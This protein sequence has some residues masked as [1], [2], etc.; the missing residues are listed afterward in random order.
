MTHL[1]VLMCLAIV[2]SSMTIR[3][4]TLAATEPLYKQIDALVT[5]HTGFRDRAA[6][7][8]NDASFLRRIHLDL[9]G[10]IPTAQQ[11]RDF[12]ADSAADK[13]VELIDKL[14]DS[15]QYARRMQVVFDVMLMERR[16]SKHIKA[17]QWEEYLW[18]SFRENKSWMQLSTEM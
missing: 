10:S 7:K 9:T 5:S 16:A 18:D 2:I 15:P 14:L 8:T 3:S 12:L 6:P 11:A 4:R 13:R 1:K 17:E